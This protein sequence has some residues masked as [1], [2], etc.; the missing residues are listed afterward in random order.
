MAHPLRRADRSRRRRDDGRRPLRMLWL[1]LALSACCAYSFAGLDSYELTAPSPGTTAVYGSLE[2]ARLGSASACTGQVFGDVNGDGFDDWIVGEPSGQPFGRVLAGMVYVFYG[3]RDPL[4]STI[5]LATGQS[6]TT[7]RMTFVQGSD[8]LFQT[9]WSVT[10]GDMDGDGYD[11]IITG[12]FTANT[13]GGRAAGGVYIVYGGPGLPGQT[14]DLAA[15][16][17]PNLTLVMGDDPDNYLGLAC[18][19]GDFDG[20]GLDDLLASAPT[21]G[22]QFTTQPGVCYIVYGD[23]ALRG[24]TVDFDTPGTLTAFNET[25]IYGD[26]ET[27]A[28]E[29]YGGFLGFSVASGDINGDGIDDAVIG[30]R[31]TGP[32]A[33]DTHYGRV[34]VV[35]GSKNLR[36]RIIDLNTDDT[37]SSEGETRIF[38]FDMDEIHTPLVSAG[39][40]NGD[41]FDDV[42]LGASVANP[43]GRTWAGNA[44]IVYGSRALPGQIVD[45]RTPD[46]P[47][48]II[49][50]TYFH[51][52][53]EQ[54]FVGTG[55]I[56]GDVNG[57]GL[58]DPILGA[59][60]VDPG[61]RDGAGRTYALLG[62]ANWDGVEIDLANEVSYIGIAI[63]GV[64]PGDAYGGN[65]AA[66]GD[67]NR[68]GVT[69]FAASALL[70]E[71]P[72]LD[73][74]N[75]AGYVSLFTDLLTSPAIGR[76]DVKDYVASGT[77]PLRG[78]GGRLSPVARTRIAF[79][80]GANPLFGASRVD[81]TQWRGAS[82]ELLLPIYQPRIASVAWRLAAA[83]D[84][85]TTA[86]V[87]FQYADDEVDH[88]AEWTL[89][90]ARAT[91]DV[92]QLLPIPEQTL[93]RR[94]NT[95]TAVVDDLGYFGIF[96]KPFTRTEDW[97][98]Y[99]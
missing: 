83:R 26:Y 91:T 50:P 64:V 17:S 61:G 39:D 51:G 52:A 48:T 37:I 31:T 25:R 19:T 93:N 24:Q 57:D 35:Y 34:Y 41:G 78:F 9:G 98:F 4:P 89:E 97:L 38:G 63:N 82:A 54:D 47:T 23:P 7:Q 18:C 45:L 80:N 13:P 22:P 3:S 76:I 36:G 77:T 66:E 53:Q 40:V 88:L 32:N 16:T 55:L 15:L 72:G 81:L 12:A 79:A 21:A 1:A 11:E 27:V 42:L 43:L 33:F 73:P 65:L 59:F 84:N 94:R 44:N 20:D 90:L 86:L 70:G 6:V 5:N 92:E 46:I 87:E 74:L 49:Q 67:F 68:D 8:L 28:P 75:D 29:D 60:G 96:G 30:G 62:Q 58:S 99:E 85:W 10:S 69:D 95:I 71:N 2:S 56:L 14:L